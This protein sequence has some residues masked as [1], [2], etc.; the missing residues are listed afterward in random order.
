MSP[1]CGHILCDPYPATC[2]FSLRIRRSSRIVNSMITR[3]KEILMTFTK[4]PFLASP[5]PMGWGKLLL[6][7]KPKVE[8]LQMDWLRSED[9][10]EE[11]NVTA[12]AI[13][14]AVE[15]P[16]ALCLCRWRGAQGVP[17]GM[18]RMHPEC[19]DSDRSDRSVAA[20]VL[21]RQE[22]DEEEDEEERKTK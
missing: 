19:P 10:K 20:D 7:E 16:I 22:P 3:P 13:I 6:A 2:G 4:R 9:L 18:S 21:L 11:K 17:L 14:I 12:P 8:E 5:A 15:E 1:Q